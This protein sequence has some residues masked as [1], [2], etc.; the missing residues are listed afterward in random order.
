MDVAYDRGTIYQPN[1]SG[2]DTYIYNDDGCFMK[3]KEPRAQFHPAS[4]LPGL[5]HKK[6]FSKYKSPNI[7]SKAVSYYQDGSGRDYYIKV[8]NGGMGQ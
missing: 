5:D 6:Y 1:G 8:N 7:H 3:M 2:R 4:V